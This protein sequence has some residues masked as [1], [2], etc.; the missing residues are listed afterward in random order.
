VEK[1]E[2]KANADVLRD[3]NKKAKATARATADP[4]GM[5][6]RKATART[7][8]KAAENATRAAS[9]RPPR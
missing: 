4:Y 2:Q 9:T 3:D 7:T 5:T 6:T 8:A 1:P